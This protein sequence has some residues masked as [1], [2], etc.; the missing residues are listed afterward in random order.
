MTS[1]SDSRG[2][3]MENNPICETCGQPDDAWNGCA[4]GCDFTVA[5]CHG[6]GA[7]PAAEDEHRACPPS[8]DVQAYPPESES[9]GSLLNRDITQTREAFEKVEETE[10]DEA[11]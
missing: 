11:P 8:C 2:P 9:L 7:C 5:Y 4:C 1:P 6:C 3:G 10:G